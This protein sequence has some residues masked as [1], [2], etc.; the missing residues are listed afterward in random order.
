MPAKA[1]ATATMPETARLMMV[2]IEVSRTIMLR[3]S[4]ARGAVLRL[5]MRKLRQM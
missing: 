4:H 5:E 2:M 3:K 1:M